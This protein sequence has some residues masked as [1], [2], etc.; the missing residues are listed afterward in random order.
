MI[1]NVKNYMAFLRH[2]SRT[3]CPSQKCAYSLEVN[4]E[5]FRRPIN[6]I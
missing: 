5:M 2:D 1:N 3:V 4:V 6:L